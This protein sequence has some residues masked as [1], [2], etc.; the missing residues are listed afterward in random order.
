MRLQKPMLATM[1]TG[2]ICA[3]RRNVRRQ[4]ERRANPF[5]F[6]SEEWI[7][8]VQQQYL[9]W[10]KQDRRLFDRRSSERRELDRRA[11]L[12]NAKREMPFQRN[13]WFSADNI[14]NDEEKQMILALFAEEK[15]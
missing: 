12:R 5:A 15:Q 4:Q 1:K 11:A 7:A 14:L 6:N 9:L 8:A 3:R 13:R 2:N 10:P